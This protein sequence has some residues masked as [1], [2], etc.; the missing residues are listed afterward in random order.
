M[1]RR[2][3]VKSARAASSPRRGEVL[4]LAAGL[5]ADR[6]YRATTVRDIA[7]AAGVLSGSLYHHFDSK[8]SMVDELLGSFLRDLHT[9]YLAIAEGDA[10]PSRQLERLVEESFDSIPRHRAAIVVYQQEGEQLALLPRF[11]YLREISAENEKIWLRVIEQGA[12][13]GELVTANPRLTYQFLRD[14]VWG[15]VRWFQLGGTWTTR[16]LSTQFMH[17]V[18]DGL[19]PR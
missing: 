13:S 9:R 16:D 17:M 18:M 19:S 1:A 6:G 4:A 2:A 10:S 7:D 5:F 14:A 15:S 12:E 3:A 11:G 8:E